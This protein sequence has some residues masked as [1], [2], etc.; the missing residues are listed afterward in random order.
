MV[1][2]GSSGML[3]TEIGLPG[4]SG[5]VLLEV[6]KAPGIR[7][8]LLG[9]S[10]APG[11]RVGVLR[12][13]VEVLEGSKVVLLGVPG[14]QGIGEVLLGGPRVALRGGPGVQ[15]AVTLLREPR[16]QD[17]GVA[18]SWSLSRSRR[19]RG[20]RLV[21]SAPSCSSCSGVRRGRFCAWGGTGGVT[22]GS[23]GSSP[24]PH[25]HTYTQRY[26][27]RCGPHRTRRPLGDQPAPPEHP[28]RTPAPART[29]GGGLGAL[30]GPGLLPVSTPVALS[31]GPAPGLGPGP[32]GS[33]S[34]PGAAAARAPPV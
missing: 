30:H 31:R 6:S 5:L 2:S 34:S 18:Q 27:E 20:V 14:M 33:G 4:A 22:G 11:L 12:P 28:N 16:A 13:R 7:V 23:T 25:T 26:R 17:T 10:E 8:G 21:R 9:T 32:A 1:L 29:H 19:S 15:R 3:D 24:P